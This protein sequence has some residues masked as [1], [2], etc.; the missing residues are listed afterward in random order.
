[1]T[2]DELR[3]WLNT[4]ERWPTRPRLPVRLFLDRGGVATGLILEGRGLTIFDY[5][6]SILYQY[7]SVEDMAD[8]GWEID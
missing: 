4:P 7:A 8:A 2:T 1:M 5:D 6:G 3:W